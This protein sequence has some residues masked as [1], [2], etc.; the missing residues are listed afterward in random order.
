MVDNKLKIKTKNNYQLVIII[1]IDNIIF[2]GFKDEI[3][4][5]YA[6]QMQ[7]VFEMYMVGELS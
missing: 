4:K 7:N 6:N 2:G 3:C 5:E 1:H